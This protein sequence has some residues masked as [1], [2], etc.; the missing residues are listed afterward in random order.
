MRRFE[1]AVE[2]PTSELVSDYE[3]LKR[4]L[5]LDIAPDTK[6]IIRKHMAQI[7]FELWARYEEG[8]LVAYESYAEQIQLTQ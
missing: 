5:K 6:Q 4:G 1:D 7:A 8:D 3:N 2:M